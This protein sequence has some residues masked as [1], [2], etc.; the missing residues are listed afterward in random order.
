MFRLAE[1]AE[2][3]VKGT[4][5]PVDLWKQLPKLY[6]QKGYSS[7]FFIRKRF[8]ELLLTVYVKSDEENAMSL[9]INAHQSLCQQLQN[10]GVIIDNDTEHQVLLFGL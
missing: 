8:Y 7:L 4:R 10:S 9:D 6:E 3:L 1:G 2:Q 5:N